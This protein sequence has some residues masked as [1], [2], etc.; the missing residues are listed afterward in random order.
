MKIGVIGA[1]YVG[2]TTAAC[3][4]QVG[5]DVFCSESDTEKL[6]KLQS[7]VMPLFEPDLERVVSET[8]AAGRLHFGSTEEAIDWGLALFIC[9]GTPPLA[10]GEADL[11]PVEGVARAI[12][13]RAK[14]YRLVVE[15]ST[16]P[17][18]TGAQVR[19]HLG[20]HK[21]HD[22]N[23]DVAS[24]PEFLREGSAVDDFLHPDRIVIGV[25]SKRAEELLREIYQPIVEHKFTCPIHRNCSSSKERMLL[26][27][28]TNSSELIKHASNSF[29]AMKISFINMVANLCEAVGADIGKVAQGMGL[30]PRI[31]P[32]FLNA[33]IGF[34]GFC[35][36]KDVQAFIRIAEKSGCDFGLLREVEKINNQRIERF[37][38]KIK[39]E[40]WSVRGKTVALWGLAFKPNTDDVRFAPSIGIARAL[41][42]EGAAVRAYDPEAAGKAKESLPQIQYCRD[43]YE[44]AEGADVILLVTEW[45][46]FRRVDWQR[47]AR[48]VERR[49]VI[50]GR[51]MFETGEMTARGFQ[52][53]SMGRVSGMPETPTTQDA[54][55]PISTGTRAS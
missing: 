17:V 52:Y 32:A 7:G 16:V 46:E 22:F 39:N 50:D 8:R 42:Q 37:V 51:N 43:P 14:G 3:L 23:Y 5:H 26:I 38:E 15:K 48:L 29:L 21:T 6:K 34:G 36:P 49:L 11:S 30:D 35:F 31:G 19:K 33:G 53:V 54:A 2:L 27:T 25:E 13:K 55:T 45:D 20:I 12:A 1:G 4:A 28:D 10:N 44:A 41:L 18:Q 47:I 9:V 24:N 40:L